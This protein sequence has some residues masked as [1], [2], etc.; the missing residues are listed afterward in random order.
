MYHAKFGV[1]GDLKEASIGWHHRDMSGLATN[2]PIYERVLRF[3]REPQPDRFENVALDVFRY[4]FAHIPVYRAFCLN[5]GADLAT[6]R[7]FA[8][9]PFASTLAF[10]HA[11]VTYDEECAA[12]SALTFKTSGTTKGFVA[13]GVHRVPYPEIYRTSALAHLRRM[14]FPE[15]QRMPLLALHPTAERMPESSLSWML[16]WCFEEFGDSS[17]LGVATPQALDVDAAGAFVRSCVRE[18][19][20]AG[21]LGTTAAFARLFDGLR[22]NPVRLPAGSRLMDTGGAKGQAVPL[23]DYEVRELAWDLLGIE[24]KC[25]INEYGMTELCSQLYDATPF[26]STAEARE[27]R[28]KLAP[29]WM[30]PVVID[31]ITLRHLPDRQIGLMAFFDLANVGSIAAIMTEDLGYTEGGAVAILGRAASGD[32]RGCALGIEQFAIAERQPDAKA[33]A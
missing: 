22:D 11:Q 20:P 33:S 25:A 9:I 19:R 2:N 27:V 17:S 18:G 4:Q 31:P 6:V 7:D 26:N 21:L 23:K 3:M 30:R 15:G 32:P 24:P 14:M 5:Q 29:P 16:S 13:R 28:L 12:P 10:K 8:A 1:T